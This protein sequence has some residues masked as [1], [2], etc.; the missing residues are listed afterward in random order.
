M[1]QHIQKPKTMLEST[2]LTKGVYT[3]RLVK[4]GAVIHIGKLVLE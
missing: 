2:N 3:Y 1:E 4:D